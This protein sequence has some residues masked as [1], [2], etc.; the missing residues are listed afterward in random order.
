M[1]TKYDK[2]T[3]IKITNV[4]QEIGMPAHLKGFYYVREA[5]LMVYNNEDLLDH[6]IDGVYVILAERYNTSLHS[7]ERLIRVAIENTW[8]R[9][10]IN[11][12]IKIFRNTID[13]RKSRPT[14]KEF[15][16]LLVDYMRIQNLQF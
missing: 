9:G 3:I 2:E 7:V 4:L 13:G 10:N 16:A 8:L 5:I 15:I 11:A 6:M 1:I 14:N 12:I